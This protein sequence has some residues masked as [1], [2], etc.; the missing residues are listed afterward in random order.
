MLVGLGSALLLC[1]G[2]FRTH[3]TFTVE[4]QAAEDLQCPRGSLVAED[5]GGDF[6]VVKGCDKEAHYSCVKDAMGNFDCQRK[7]TP[8]KQ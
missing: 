6:F 8:E 7:D 5:L 2:C 3:D 1:G 4:M